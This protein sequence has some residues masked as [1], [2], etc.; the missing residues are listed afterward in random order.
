MTDP[1][2][3][4]VAGCK[5]ILDKC[6]DVE[7]NLSV[8]TPEFREFPWSALSVRY[9]GR[10]FARGFARRLQT[11]RGTVVIVSP[12]ERCNKKWSPPA[13]SVP[14]IVRFSGEINETRCLIRRPPGEKVL[15]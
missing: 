2:L 7:T 15:R 1:T 13:L 5:N 14:A 3:R 10:Y 11:T 6:I 4:I 8:D 12:A 9:R